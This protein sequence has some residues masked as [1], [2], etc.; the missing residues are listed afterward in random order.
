[1]ISKKTLTRSK[2]ATFE[3]N[4]KI[5][6]A[7]T[8]VRLFVGFLES[9]GAST[10]NPSAGLTYIDS[11]GE[12]KLYED[13]SNTTIAA[14]GAWVAGD[15]LRIRLKLNA[16]GF[17]YTLWRNGNY[18]SSTYTGNYGTDATATVYPALLF[19]HSTPRFEVYSASAWDDDSLGAFNLSGGGTFGFISD[20]GNQLLYTTQG[21]T[22]KSSNAVID[23]VS[24]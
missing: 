6:S 16:S 1:M 10:F 15:T 7:V 9:Q 19:Y 23:G 18:N 5:L 12:F 11:N 2:N 3:V 24:G 20:N 8:Q 4:V 13:A 21:V 14:S 22:L 17:T